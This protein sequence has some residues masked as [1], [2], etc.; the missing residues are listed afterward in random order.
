MAA[1]DR[2]E[3]ERDGFVTLPR[4]LD[5]GPLKAELINALE[6]GTR[7]AMATGVARV[8]YV[9][10]MHPRSTPVSLALL[11]HFQALAAEALGGS[12]LPVR[13][14]GMRYFGDTSWHVDSSRPVASVGF[15]AYLEPLTAGQGALRVRP[16]SHR[17]MP[18]AE[19]AIETQPGE[20][21]VF[22]EHLQHASSGGGQRHQWRVDFVREPR[23]AQEEEEVRAYFAAIF[24]ADWDGGVDVEAFP[25][26]PSGWA[27]AGHRGAARLG[28]LGVYALA[29]R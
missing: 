8:Q 6:L 28:E 5:A 27:P 10:M 29:A 4:A 24:P 19:V 16:G 11:H 12:V 22:D 26:Y 3:F 7:R 20:V 23:S 17:G 13:A 14:K 1:F 25:S 15:L 9:P 2:A 18:S 21:I